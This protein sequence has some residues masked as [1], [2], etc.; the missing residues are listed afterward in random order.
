MLD[1]IK[2]SISVDFAA[3]YG[4]E[5]GNMVNLYSQIFLNGEEFASS[6]ASR[7]NTANEQLAKLLEYFN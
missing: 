3:A 6:W 2:G 1:L 4:I 5:L 7:K